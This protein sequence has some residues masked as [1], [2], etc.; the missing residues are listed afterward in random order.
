[1]S[2][3]FSPEH[4]SVSKIHD[5]LL[6]L[7]KIKNQMPPPLAALAR[8]QLLT[9]EQVSMLVDA[10]FWA[11]LRL[12][13]G[14]ITC[15]SAAVTAPESFCAPLLFAVAVP[16]DE[17]QI[18]KLAPALPRGGCIGVS[19]EGDGLGIWG[20][21]RIRPGSWLDTVTVDVWEPGTVR[22]G[23]GPFQPFAVLNGRSNPVMAGSPIF[24]AD[25]LRRVL[26]KVLPTG[27]ILET[28]AVW[29]EC[30]ALKDLARMTVAEGH[31]GAVLI[32]PNETGAWLDSL[33]PFAYRL[34][35]PDTTVPGLIRLELNQAQAQGEAVQRL[36]AT[37]LDEGLKASIMAAM[38]PGSADIG[39][40]VGAIASLGGVDGAVVVTRDLQLLGFGAKIAVGGDVSPQV[41]IYE[42]GS[43][44]VVCSPL[45]SLGGTRHQS[46][47]RFVGRNRDT[48]ALVISQD[49]YLSIMH[50]DEAANSVAVLRNAEWWV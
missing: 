27:D 7:L 45:E 50:W 40:S 44:R 3:L 20:F 22:V 24:L 48:V 31:G 21:C 5:Q 25:Y 13:E 26:G 17:S 38:G 49:R 36:S 46:A 18:A 6:H 11:S 14:R 35:S 8:G 4:D 12:K 10:A 33:N 15:F 37:E 28:Q 47:A 29:R 32:V 2:T 39:R 19:G 30:L 16:Y 42:P 23:V 34:A 1:M 43:Q 9:R 41:L